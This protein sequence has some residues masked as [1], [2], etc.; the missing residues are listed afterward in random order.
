MESM[1]F[2]SENPSTP[3]RLLHQLSQL[4]APLHIEWFN[5]QDIGQKTFPPSPHELSEPHQACPIAAPHLL[6]QAA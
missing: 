5:L 1:D 2:S 4:R 3:S 6:G